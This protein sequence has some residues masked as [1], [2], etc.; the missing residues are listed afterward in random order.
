MPGG[1]EI[2][3]SLLARCWISAHDADKDT[4]GF[5][6]KKVVLEKYE[7]EVIEEVV[8]PRSDKFPERRMGT[9]VVVLGAGEEIRVGLELFGS[10]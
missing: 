1:Q 10:D 2:A 6:S 4:K 3:Q 7:K 5:A 9:E 8:S